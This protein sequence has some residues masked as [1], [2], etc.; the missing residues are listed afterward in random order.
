ME[1]L[2]EHP[3]YFSGGGAVVEVKKHFHSFVEKSEVEIWRDQS[4]VPVDF[5]E[6]LGHYV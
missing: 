6:P 2:V 5:G 4:L 3:D 1:N